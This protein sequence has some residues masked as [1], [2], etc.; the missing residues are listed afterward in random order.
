MFNANSP[1]YPIDSNSSGMDFA[2]RGDDPFTWL[3]DSEYFRALVDDPVATDAEILGYIRRCDFGVGEFLNLKG[4][5]GG[6]GGVFDFYRCAGSGMDYQCGA[7]PQRI[8][9]ERRS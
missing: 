4:G 6:E 1:E 7:G 3:G 9:I 5:L 8:G 2:L